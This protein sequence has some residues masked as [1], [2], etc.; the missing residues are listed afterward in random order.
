MG[1]RS[2]GKVTEELLAGWLSFTPVGLLAEAPA[3]AQTTQVQINCISAVRP[4]KGSKCSSRRCL[5]GLVRSN[6]TISA[7]SA[8]VS[9]R[10]GTLEGVIR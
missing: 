1:E 3:M 10:Q 8:E 2:W 9:I 7:R 6:P 5:P 4:W